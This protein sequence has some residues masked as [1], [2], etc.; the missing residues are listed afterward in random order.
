MYWT[1]PFLKTL[2]YRGI[3]FKGDINKHP[4]Y[5]REAYEAGKIMVAELPAELK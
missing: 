2:A 5:I 3:D 4:E 1:S